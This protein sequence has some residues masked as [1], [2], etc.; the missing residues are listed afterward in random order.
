V[1]TPRAKASYH[2]FRCHYRKHKEGILKRAT[3][4]LLAVILLLFLALP[5]N[6]VAGPRQD[7][8]PTISEF[9][10]EYILV[11]FKPGT[12]LPEAAQI[13][14]QLGGQVK[15]TIPG[16]GVQVVKVPK[17]QAKEK[18]KAYSSNPMVAY[19]ELD[20][21]A[22][23]L[24]EPDDTYFPSQWGMQK[25]QAPEAWNITTG[26][27]GVIIAILDTGVDTGHPDLIDKIVDNI[28]FTDSPTVD[29]VYG[30]GTHVAGIAAASTDNGMGVAGL[31]YDSTIMNVKVL[32]DS[33]GGY[34]SWAAAGIT[35]AADN[36]ADVI[37]LSLGG[38]SGSQILE[39]AVNYAWSKGVV[40]VAA[41][42]NNGKS[43]PFYPAVYDNC[44]A[45]AATNGNDVRPAWST[46]G[47]WVDVAA[48]GREIYST[49]R[50]G[51]YGY[52]SGTSMAAP[53]VA[54]LAAL[55][56]TTVSDTNGDGKLNDDI[57]SRIESTCDDIG[58]EGIGSGRINAARAVGGATV[59]PGTVSGQVTDAEEGSPIAG[60]TVTDGTRTTTTDA[61][62]EYTIADV[63]P[64]TYEV[65]ASKEGYESS[66]LTVTVL[67]GTT[68]VADFSLSQ[69]IVPGTITGSVTDAEDGSPIIGAVVTDGT[70]TTT[71]DAAGQ[72]TIADVPPGSYQVVASKE[73]YETSSATVNVLQGTTAVANIFLSQII[74]PGTITGTVTDA[75][76]GSPVVGAIVS[77]GTRTVVT[78]ATGEYTI[79]NVPPGS[80]Q[81]VASKEGY[82]SSSA[83]VNVLQGTTAVANIFLSQIIVPG[84]ITGLVTDAKDGSA[85]WGA[86]VSD[87]IRTVLTDA[88]GRYTINDVPPG[89]YQVVASKEGYE[90]LT[91]TATVTVLEGST[92]VADLSLTRI[93]VPGTITG[94]VTDAKD[95]S[96]IAGATVTDGT[97]T[98]LTDAAGQYTINDVPPGSYEIVVSKEGYE[99]S[100]LTV[101]VLEGF[102]AIADLCLTRIIVPGTITG[103]VTDAEDGSPIVGAAVNDGTRT[104]VT[105]ATGQY[106]INDVRPGSYQVVASKEGYESSSLTMT[107]LE[108]NTA[109]ADLSLT[110]IIVPG[111]ITGR[112]TDAEDGSPIAGATVSD[113]T[114]TTTTDT[115]G[116]YTIANVPPGTY[117]VTA[118]KSGYESS[119]STVTVL[120]GGTAV[121]NFSLN[122]N[123]PP[124]N[125]I[126]VDT[127]RFKQC[128]VNLFIEIEVVTASGVVPGA[129]VALSLEW[130]SGELWNFSGTT[131][132]AGIIKFKLG[133]APTGSYLTTVN[134]LTCSGFIWDMSKGITSTSYA[135]NR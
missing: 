9:S 77:D 135:L 67:E 98:V 50:D 81:V 62:G 129:N 39:D 132:N 8:P 52:K 106:T 118:S 111:T 88:A 94:S 38:K 23:I 91:S 24:A 124:S 119:T 63:P 41:A 122:R 32:G 26:S 6:A 3:I 103:S 28:N 113:G 13:H 16:I 134:S 11:K 10:S 126:W 5:I 76:D 56:L 21:V 37:N 46:Y 68:A 105:D 102:T 99:R 114:R 74:V 17:G 97:R 34:Y 55:V 133:K 72:Y 2:I 78:D 54:G 89:S 18:A 101:I 92:A 90:I 60:A 14:R 131:N 100:S 49:L 95:G 20:Y 86:Q 128:G 87:G 25:I 15:D 125:A 36:G 22:Q 73:G 83:T 75:E 71:A 110:R 85:I 43:D 104:V 4:S 80:Y 96:P 123:A 40:V 115:T 108:G 27:P 121:M 69:T 120:S 1:I 31:G 42:G 47:D 65:V 30:H 82:E 79:D 44:I 107:V 58:V 53:H 33:G 57:R 117:E 66:S 116:K 130:S 109:V 70:R 7:V 19:A 29:D 61:S 84:S 35:W 48:P 45:V 59:L 93:I 51:S 112:V 64:G 12:G 127:V